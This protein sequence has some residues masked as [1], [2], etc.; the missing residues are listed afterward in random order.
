MPDYVIRLATVADAEPIRAIYNYYVAHSTCTYQI[1]P[2]TAEERVA[3][4]RDRAPRHPAI[5][6]DD[7]GT[8]VA[9]GALSA[10]R[11]RC[12]YAE[13]AEAS[14]YVHHEH[15]RRG[16]GRAL[17]L[18]L[19]ARGRA[20]GLHT[21]I[22]AASADQTASIALQLALGFKETGRL[23]EVGTKFGRRLD[24][25]FTQLMLRA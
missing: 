16:L 3:W 12:G 21:I 6:A 20:A 22:G 8:V 7:N 2:E 17:L 19:I 24:V 4:L 14:V 13:S 11:S 18:D 9:W 25:V 1:E 10:W 23:Y 15:H 5:V